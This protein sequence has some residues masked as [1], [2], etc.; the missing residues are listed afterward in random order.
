ML[1]E[2][3]HRP[4]PGMTLFDYCS[5]KNTK[6]IALPQTKVAEIIDLITPYMNQRRKLDQF[7]L[8]RY[9]KEA[10]DNLN[11]DPRLGYIALGMIAV[12]QSD[13]EGLDIAYQKAIAIKN[14]SE[15]HASYA[16]ALQMVGR[17]NEAFHEAVVASEKEPEN[18]TLL[19]RAIDYSRHA[20]KYA[21]G[22]DLVTKYAQRAPGKSSEAQEIIIDVLSIFQAREFSENII[23]QCNDIA[24]SILRK[25]KVPYIKTKFRTDIQD[26][27]IMYFIYVLA[28]DEIAQALD[29]ELGIEL[30]DN[31]EGYNPDQYWIG[32]EKVEEA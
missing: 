5:S 14:D 7:T 4:S 23:S 22:L 3:A 28:S 30:F 18:L 11:V 19:E 25:N 17:F 21:A 12:L 32:F 20:G 13:Y 8:Q 31:V 6:M 24:F 29:E 27:Y 1:Q 2:V 9:K 16:N 26:N 10:S 15:S